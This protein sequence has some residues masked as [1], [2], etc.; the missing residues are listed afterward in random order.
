[1][2]T[3]TRPTGGPGTSGAPGT[4]GAVSTA[5]SQREVVAVVAR[6]E[7]LARLRDRTFLAST[8]FLLV[9]VAASIAVPLLLEGGD[10]PRYT[11]AAV[12]GPARAVAASAA[13]LGEQA[14][15]AQERADARDDDGGDGTAAVTGPQDAAVTVPAAQVEVREV[16]DAA[17]AEAL[18]RDGTADAALVGAGS[19]LQ[20]VGDEEVPSDLADLLAAAGR[21]ATLLAGLGAAGVA[22]DRAQELFRQAA[23]AAPAE[24]LLDPPT[25]DAELALPLSF[26][27]AML[28][29][30]TTFLFGMA[31]A[32]SVVEEKQ[33]RIVEI[34]VAAV[35]VRSL[36]AGKVLG[37]TALAIGQTVLLV[38]VALAA[39]SIGGQGGLVSVI[40]RSG[41]VFLVFFLLGFAML[42][43][44]WAAAGALASRQED[45][46]AT[47]VPMQVLLFVPLFAGIYVTSTG[48][49]LTVLSYVPF[50]APLTMP[51]RLLL[52]DAAWWE[53]VVSAGLVVATAVAFVGLATRIYERSVLRSGSRVPWSAALG[54]RRGNAGA[55]AE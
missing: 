8:A 31:I 15:R 11:V 18:V 52:Q 10:A 55:A 26:V 45:L 22:P 27:F 1:M 54:L 51:R 2:T 6:R 4:C 35:P 23:Q 37:N 44:L 7:L 28:F 9:V 32:Q 21:D 14:T 12:G 36:L 41:G 48:P 25:E 30:F 13:S 29:F 38:A 40:L 47:T 5:P 16:P 19:G 17:A 34:L 42:A 53:P 43:C 24:R 20:V 46:Q 3:T 50:T 49:L 33:S 39:A